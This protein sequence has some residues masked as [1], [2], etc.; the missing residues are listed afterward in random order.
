LAK[1]FSAKDSKITCWKVLK[2]LYY[3]SGSS[4][5]NLSNP[6]KTEIGQQG[7]NRWQRKSGGR[8]RGRH[9]ENSR[10]DLDCPVGSRAPET[11]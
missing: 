10:K 4:H 7:L 6:G 5:K 3:F 1:R 11:G 8:G 2:W 9:N